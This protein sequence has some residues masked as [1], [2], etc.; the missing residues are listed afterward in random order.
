MT[1]HTPADALIRLFTQ[2]EGALGAFGHDLEIAVTAFRIEL[3]EANKHVD[4]RM[5]A[6]SLKVLHALTDGRPDV[7]ALGPHDKAEIE[8]H[9]RDVLH[10]ARFPEIRFVG[11]ADGAGDLTGELT[12]HGET[13]PVRIAWH[14]ADHSR[15]AEVTF[16]HRDFGIRP[17]RAML[18]ALRVRPQVRVRVV[19]PHHLTQS[20][21]T[22]GETD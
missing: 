11:R 17:Y 4:A 19:L 12:L 6:N 20:S 5:E 1:T 10:S 16:D 21:E 22:Q 13:H 18:G 14:E 15:V 7:E 9:I 3:D 8:A 2:R